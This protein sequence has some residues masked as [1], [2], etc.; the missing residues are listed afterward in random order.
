MVAG[1]PLRVAHLRR[2]RP[3]QG[4]GN[5]QLLPKYALGNKGATVGEARLEGWGEAAE[6]WKKEELESHGYR[7]GE[8]EDEGER[9]D[10]AKR[11]Q[12]RMAELE[13]MRTRAGPRVARIPAAIGP[14]EEDDLPS[15]NLA[16][17][18]A[19]MLFKDYLGYQEFNLEDGLTIDVSDL[20]TRISVKEPSKMWVV[21]EENRERQNEASER[22]IPGEVD[23]DQIDRY[24][25]VLMDFVRYC[26]KHGYSTLYVI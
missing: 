9:E 13:E 25:S 15:L 21:R 3:F 20:A 19:K 11:H 1:A 23:E 17:G 14:P 26:R 4:R 24:V 7:T 12:G 8:A 18:N 5:D 22:W 10:E 16:N 2:G 6:K